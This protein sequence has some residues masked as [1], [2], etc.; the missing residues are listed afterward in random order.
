MTKDEIFSFTLGC[1]PGKTIY[2]EVEMRQ[3]TCFLTKEHQG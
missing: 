3:R 1:N 2:I